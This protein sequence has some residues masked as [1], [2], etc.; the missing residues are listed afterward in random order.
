M[1]KID[2]L[3]SK[4]CSLFLM[5]EEIFLLEFSNPTVNSRILPVEK[6]FASERCE[7]LSMDEID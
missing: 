5:L 6:Y 4:R 1:E 3:K 7:Q 2:D